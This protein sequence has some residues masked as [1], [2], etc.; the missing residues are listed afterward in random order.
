MQAKST[1]GSSSNGPASSAN[2]DLSMQLWIQEFFE[3]GDLEQHH[4]KLTG[5][6]VP[7]TNKTTAAVAAAEAAVVGG[8]GGDG[9]RWW[10]SASA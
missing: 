2:L 10:R 8:G 9:G 7:A 5:V 1:G 3:G 4:K 6:E